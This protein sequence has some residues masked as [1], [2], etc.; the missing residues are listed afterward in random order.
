MSR[1]TQPLARGRVAAR[2]WAWY[3]A[4]GAVVLTALYLSFPPLA[5]NASG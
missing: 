2:V 5:G 4:A 3:L 1:L